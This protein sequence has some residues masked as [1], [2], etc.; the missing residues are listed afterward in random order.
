LKTT[1]SLTAVNTHQGANL[2]TAALARAIISRGRSNRF[3]YQGIGG[4]LDFIQET[5]NSDPKPTFSNAFASRK[6]AYEI[7]LSAIP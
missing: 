4:L 6:P 7:G 3:G 2:F 5:V 1:G